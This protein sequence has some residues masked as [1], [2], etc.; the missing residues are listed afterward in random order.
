GPS[1]PAPRYPNLF[2]F[3]LAP[4]QGHSLDENMK[5]LDD[6]LARF[7]AQ[8][9]DAATME[10]VKTKVRAGVIRSLDSNP[11]LAQLITSYEANYGDWRKLFTAIDD[12]NKVTA[13]DVQR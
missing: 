13:A 7:K 11:G 3:V 10:R 1:F 2:V 9:V 12:L 8:T 4:A 6:L 5:E